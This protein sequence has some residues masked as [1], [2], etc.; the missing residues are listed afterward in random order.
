MKNRKFLGTLAFVGVVVF[1]LVWTVTSLLGLLNVEL[2]PT[3]TSVF[4]LIRAIATLLLILVVVIVGWEGASGKKVWMQVVFFIF[5]I[6]S[7]VGA[8][9]AIF[10]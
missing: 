3:I 6:L 2:G 7:V 5:A 10:S 4:N 1:G 8:V 9:L